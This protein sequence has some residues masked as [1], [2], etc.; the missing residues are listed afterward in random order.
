[1]SIGTITITARKP[2]FRTPYE[3]IWPQATPRVVVDDGPET[4]LPWNEP[5]TFDVSYGEHDVV[6]NPRGPWTVKTCCW[7][8][9]DGVRLEAVT[10]RTSGLRRDRIRYLA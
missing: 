2:R 1:M 5:I 4:E 8:D 6:M 3:W 7:V 10:A 9:E